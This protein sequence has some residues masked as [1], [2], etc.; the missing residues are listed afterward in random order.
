M[1][2]LP[3]TSGRSLPAGR[4]AGCC[5]SAEAA[6]PAAREL[7][8]RSR[9]GWGASPPSQVR[10][11]GVDGGGVAPRGLGTGVRPTGG[12]GASLL[13]GGPLGGVG[14]LLLWLL[15]LRWGVPGAR[16]R[17]GPQCKGPRPSCFSGLRN[18]NTPPK[19][20][21]PIER[22]GDRLPQREGRKRKRKEKGSRELSLR[23]ILSSSWIA[24]VSQ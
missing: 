16:R 6:P 19:A 13:G 7:L 1:A 11:P 23:E 14:L 4:R 20:W 24:M 21:R 22:L 18:G 8:R 5:L 10:P 15:P 17:A 3:L 9:A 12:T 2:P